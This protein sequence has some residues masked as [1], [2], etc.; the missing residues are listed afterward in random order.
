MWFS[1][2]QELQEAQDCLQQPFQHS[3]F[4]I[5]Q[6]L[7]EAGRSARVPA[8]CLDGPQAGCVLPMP[9]TSSTCV[10]GEWVAR[11][12]HHNT[13]SAHCSH[14]SKTP[15]AIKRTE[16]LK[17]S[18][19][20]LSLKP[21]GKANSHSRLRPSHMWDDKHWNE[22]QIWSSS[23]SCW[24]HSNLSGFRPSFYSCFLVGFFKSFLL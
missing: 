2:Q 3:S 4:C 8:M 14:C 1:R 13:A 23:F 9:P 21:P 24:Q 12:W 19:R 6:E 15:Q 5:K 10:K 18:P 7:A 11:V 20:V 16:S 17:P 22:S